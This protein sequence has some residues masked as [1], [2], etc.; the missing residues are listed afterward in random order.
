LERKNSTEKSQILL[1][2]KNIVLAF[3][4]FF[5]FATNAVPWYCSGITNADPMVK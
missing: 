5:V 1:K 2:M 3:C 4:F